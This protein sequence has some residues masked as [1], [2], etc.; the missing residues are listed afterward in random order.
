MNGLIGLSSNCSKNLNNKLFSYSSVFNFVLTLNIG[1]FSFFVQGFEHNLKEGTNV[2][3][4]NGTFDPPTLAHLEIIK[5]AL[6]KV[7]KNFACQELG[8]K[9]DKVIVSVNKGG[10]KDTYTAAIERV[11]M[12][13]SALRVYGEKVQV[14]Q[15]T[16]EERDQLKN[17][18]LKDKINLYQMIGE[19]SFLN[20]KI[21][22]TELL[23][24]NNNQSLG[25]SQFI[26]LPR[27]S[28]NSSNNTM[29]SEKIQNAISKSSG[30]VILFPN[31]S[32]DFSTLSSTKA[33]QNIDDGKALD[34]IVDSSVASI[35]RESGYYLKETQKEVKS[36]NEKLF[37]EGF[38]DFI[39]DI[40]KA[41]PQIL[42]SIQNK[43]YNNVQTKC[44]TI[45]TEIKESTKL[46]YKERQSESRWGEKYIEAVLSTIKD[47]EIRDLMRLKIPYM[48]VSRFQ[49]KSYGK[50]P[51]LTPVDKNILTFPSSGRIEIDEIKEN[52]KLNKLICSSEESFKDKTNYN[53]DID[54]YLWDR[55][56]KG[57]MDFLKDLKSNGK[58]M[59]NSFYLSSETLQE[60]LKKWSEYLIHPKDY[61][62]Y[63]V[64]TRRG[65]P[66]RNL[67]LFYNSLTQKYGLMA[68][69]VIG[70]DRRA[71]VFC[72]IRLTEVFDHYFDLS[73]GSKNDFFQ[74]N[75]EGQKLS[76]NSNDLLIFGY[77]TAWMEDLVSSTKNKWKTTKLTNGSVVDLELMEISDSEGN[78]EVESS[79]KSPTKKLSR[80]ILARNVFGDEASFVLEKLYEK[81]LRKVL[82][83]GT[84]GALPNL[85]IGSITLPT[86]FVDKSLKDIS[87]DQSWAV[88][89]LKKG[90]IPDSIPVLSG[91][92]HAWVPHLFD[93]TKHQLIRWRK[94]GVASID[95][96]GYHISKFRMLHPDMQM[97]LF[98]I[99]SD[100]TLGSSTIEQSNSHT[101]TI[102][103]SVLELIRIL[104]PQLIA[105][106]SEL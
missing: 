47:P 75:E 39:S 91:M 20:L 89:L 44:S 42:L 87:F 88:E 96:E 95:V 70:N 57:F 60:T 52:H 12:L 76:L 2:A 25:K 85:E 99:I 5:C 15:S 102:R 63:F 45:I 34:G 92:K 14:I 53:M 94:H 83:M 80:L 71:N 9:I 50:L 106:P 18:L 1:L 33:R 17:N 19:D 105:N 65:Q 32:S 82:Y 51:H 31:L 29:N 41:C 36:L 43:V 11:L 21:D 56:P 13:E 38:N 37:I 22:A 4:Y 40:E 23:K 16:P 103:N 58:L 67:Y 6:G 74:F 59:S 8:Q 28:E 30:Q 61:S 46:V 93:E 86:S 49:G 100:Q 81:G 64:Q 84:A 7:D 69:Q 90:S 73:A 104:R 101:K 35:I 54:R 98:Y 68:T 79:K 48:I 66:H 24:S 62:F 3:Y 10:D 55:F 77:K 97:A 72:Q 26:I 78:Q 27:D